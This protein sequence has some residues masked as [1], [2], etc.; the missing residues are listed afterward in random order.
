MRCAGTN[1]SRSRLSIVTTSSTQEISQLAPD[2]N[3]CCLD[4][5]TVDYAVSVIRAALKR[6]L[7]LE[8]MFTHEREASLT[9]LETSQGSARLIRSLLRS[10]PGLLKSIQEHC[11]IRPP[12]NMQSGWQYPTSAEP[13]KP[14]SG[15]QFEADG[16]RSWLLD[17]ETKNQQPRLVIKMGNIQLLRPI[18]S[19]PSTE[20]ALCRL[21]GVP[22][23]TPGLTSLAGCH[24][25]P[26]LDILI[27]GTPHTLP[28][29]GVSS[30]L[31]RH[32]IYAKETLM[33]PLGQ[34][35]PKGFTI[36]ARLVLHKVEP[37]PSLNW[38]H[39]I[40]LRCPVAA[41]R[42]A[43]SLYSTRSTIEFDKLVE[44]NLIQPISDPVAIL[45]V[46]FNKSPDEI[47]VA[48]S[49]S[50]DIEIPSYK[51]GLT[52]NGIY[53]YTQYDDWPAP[54]QGLL[55]IHPP[56]Q[57]PDILLIS[58]TNISPNSFS[59][60]PRVAGPDK[61]SAWSSPMASTL[62]MKSNEL[63]MNLGQSLAASKNVVEQVL[64]VSFHCTVISG[65]GGLC[66]MWISA[67]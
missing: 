58:Y 18:E 11:W 66:F 57:T 42:V 1:Q 54:T 8:V 53:L 32:A 38:D 48:F 7:G 59:L 45:T 24:S 22:P 27:L 40:A 52:C 36:Y 14:N 15:Q 31:I 61:P 41:D 50:R 2:I 43:E 13:I 60:A 65:C 10:C 30:G 9:L 26:P 55:Q 5:G 17:H 16:V 35:L 47:W 3:I 46:D 4:I 28:L 67:L 12:N 20:L 33:K 44:K 63:A 62:A 29:D 56:F 49:H 6:R 19:T 34:I 21:L 25:L 51:G 23:G 39:V 37:N 64:S